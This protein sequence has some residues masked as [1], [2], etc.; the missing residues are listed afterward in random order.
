[1][2]KLFACV[3]GLALLFY[4][5][6]WRLPSTQPALLTSLP[7]HTTA[8]LAPL[9]SRPVCTSLPQALGTLAGTR[10]ILPPIGFLDN[11]QKPA[12][13]QKLYLWL[14]DNISKADAVIIS[15]DL[16]I[17]GGLT[18]SRQQ[19]GSGADEKQFME[20]MGRLRQEYPAKNISAFSIVPRLLVSDHLLPDSWYQWHLMRYATLRDMTETFGDLYLTRQQEKLAAQIPP[21][22]LQKYLNLYKTND[23]FNRSFVQLAANNITTVVG[24]DDGSSFG[25]P[26][27]NLT[28]A[29]MY[30]AHFENSYTTYGADELAAV[31][32]ARN[33]LQSMRRTPKIYLQYAA[34]GMEFMYMPFMAASVG[35]TLRDK[36]QL[37]GAQV[38]QRAADADIIIYVNCGSDSF[39][40]GKKQA[41]ELAQLID[42]GKSVAL[43][44]LAA[45]FTED[46]LLM[47]RLLDRGAPLNRLTAYAGWNTFSNSA[48]TA[49]AQAVIVHVRSGKLNSDEL[50]ALRAANMRFI[51]TRLLDDYAYQKLYHHQL[52][53]TL[54]QHD[55]DPDNLSAAG[56]G[57]A[58]MLTQQFINRKA[59]EL[60]H[61]NLGR[62]PFYTADGK[63]YY[64][65]SIDTG[66]YFP[67]NRV[68]EVGLDV[69]TE[70]GVKKY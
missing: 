16:L 55:Y 3:I 28:H 17:H 5:V 53:S 9:D 49:L 65:R 61:Y 13:R 70:V 40:P 2:K 39:K 47:P 50:A 25:L 23:D 14:G 32:I 57:M 29:Q 8:L 48:G 18:N 19:Y 30:G 12:D 21:E 38:V 63:D 34:D 66:V 22:I 7:C 51:V 1:M 4:F 6:C 45:D 68:F 59:A 31:L 11:Y 56:Q 33:Y 69:K 60:L 15:A 44:D 41:D 27:R 24:Q 43:I 35:Q 52:R 26:N 36:V 42:S 46:E 10:V 64:L 37:L 58:Q 20:V 62:T 67:W 54:K